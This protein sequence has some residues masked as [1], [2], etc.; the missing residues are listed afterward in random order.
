MFRK[1]TKQPVFCTHGIDRMAFFCRICDEHTYQHAIDMGLSVGPE[2][3][4]KAKYSA[5]LHE[6]GRRA[7]EIRVGGSGFEDELRTRAEQERQAKKST[8]NIFKEIREMMAESEAKQVRE[9]KQRQAEAKQVEASRRARQRQHDVDELRKQNRSQL[10]RFI[11]RLQKT[12]K[13]KKQP[14]QQKQ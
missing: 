1:I 3:I 12:P 13:Q 8:Q 11:K 10:A 6:L 7:I 9:R 14:K 5:K 2:S 4:S